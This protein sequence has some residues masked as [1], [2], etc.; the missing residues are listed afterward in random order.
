MATAGGALPRFL[1]AFQDAC[2][3]SDGEGLRACVS[4]RVVPYDALQRDVQPVQDANALCSA[5]LDVGNA[6]T[7]KR[8][9][10]LAAEV[11]DYVRTHLTPR[12]V[13]ADADVQAYD[14]WVKVYSRASALFALPEM[15][16]MVPALKYVAQELVALAIRVD[17]AGP[18]RAYT[19]TIDAAGRLSKSAGL[20]ANDRSASPGP[21]TKRAAVLA[22]ANLSFRA[23]F[24]LNNTRLCETVL[25]SVQNAL[26]MN[27]RYHAPGDVDTAALTGEEGY[28]L[29]ERVT[30]RFY[31]GQLRLIQHCVHQ[32]AEHLRWAFD[33]CTS[34]HMHNRRKILIP[35]VAAYLILGRY[36]TPT[37]LARFQLT[38]VFGALLHY[39][40]LGY[41]AAVERELE[42]H[43]DWLRARGL[44]L[45]L[46]EKAMLGVWRNLFRRCLTLIQPPDAVTS[47][48]SAPPTLLLAA[49]VRP[50]RFAWQDASLT[51]DD[52]ECVAANLIDQVR[53]AIH[54]F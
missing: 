19:K 47:A 13:P 9:A 5:Q 24:K 32:A 16:W 26:L 8:F 28:P 37:L 39:H 29:A 34:A 12:A 20:A 3:V 38:D 54:N 2:R 10:A 51:I 7:H 48:P 44:Y 4:V 35:L 53:G 15:A 17:T 40:R 11:L 31:L 27:R 22:L 52:M 45:L 1:S 49:L 30:Y 41:G 23:Y 36:A 33:H 6:A 21:A 25:G 43:R 46:S 14:D 42:R 18:S 50:A